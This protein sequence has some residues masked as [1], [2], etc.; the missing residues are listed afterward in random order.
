[1]PWLKLKV[2]KAIGSNIESHSGW[3]VRGYCREEVREDFSEKAIFEHMHERN[4]GD[5]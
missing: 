3:E 4:E 2:G 5:T 1:M